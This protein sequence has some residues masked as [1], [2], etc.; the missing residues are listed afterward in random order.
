AASGQ[1]SLEPRDHRA[2]PSAS[3]DLRHPRGNSIRRRRRDSAHQRAANAPGTKTD[4]RIFV[5]GKTLRRGRQDRVPAGHGGV[6]AETHG[7]RCPLQEVLEGAQAGL[8]ES[9]SSVL[10]LAPCF[11]LPAPCFPLYSFAFFS[12]FFSEVFSAGLSLDFSEVLSED[13]VFT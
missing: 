2:L 11:S 5:R 3:R 8:A 13:S 1:G 4:G 7:S 6:C 10:I 12:F 9:R